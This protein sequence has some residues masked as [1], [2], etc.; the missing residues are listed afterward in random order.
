MYSRRSEL[1]A[2][3]VV[4]GGIAALLALLLVATGRGFMEG[5]SRWQVRFAPGDAAPVVGD[6]VYYLGLEVGRVAR[7]AQGSELRRGEQLTAADRERLARM[8]AGTPQ[9]VRE[10]YVLAELELGADQQLP[11]G[12]TAR[13]KSNLV[14]GVPSLVL[15]PGISSEW[16]GAAE[17]LARPIL[18]T[19]GASLDDIA[20]KV[21]QLVQHLIDATGQLGPT[22]DEAKALLQDV[23]RKVEALDTQ[24]MSDEALAALGSL[25]RSLAVVERDMDAI[26]TNVLRATDDLR[27]LAAAGKETVEEARADV[28]EALA[29]LK[30]AS[31]RV[32]ELVRS[33]APKVDAF[34]DEVQGLGNG[35]KGLVAD[36]RGLGP[37]ARRVV[38]EAGGD[39]GTI[40]EVL[41]DAARN[42]L[43]ATE[44]IR[45]HPWKLANKPDDD[46]V[47]Y[48]NL[49]VAALTYVRAMEQMEDAA[50][51]LREVL[52]APGGDA[53]EVK[54]RVAG[55]LAA[56]EATRRRY[57][58]AEQGLGR[59]LEAYGPR[60]PR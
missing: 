50:R 1:L 39:L 42:V 2:G 30:S 48:E 3:L 15:V 33:G 38:Q 21:D 46:Q 36:F 17:T 16:M 8:P 18:G 13:L 14:T 7:V 41:E 57:E 12:T 52:A 4:L 47:A 26:A 35:L 22:V 56:F 27:S 51:L 55:T 49:R 11:R 9:E 28:G 5:F 6:T 40:F 10:V 58:E 45:A 37:D 31:A 29:S 59:L 19:Q 44:D 54:A 20:S 34:L 53:E 24:A 60:A 43:D 25:K 32:D 23:R